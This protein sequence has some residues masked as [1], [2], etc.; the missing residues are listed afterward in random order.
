MHLQPAFYYLIGSLCLAAAIVIAV[1][2][3]CADHKRDI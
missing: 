3:A 2:G 1:I